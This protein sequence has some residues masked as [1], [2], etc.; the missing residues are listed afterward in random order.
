MRVPHTS[1]LLD[2]FQAAAV[3]LDLGLRIGSCVRLVK[4]AANVR[5][6]M[7]ALRPAAANPGIMASVRAGWQIGRVLRHSFQKEG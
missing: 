7:S 2:S 1:D 4:V 3:D 6:G 5:L